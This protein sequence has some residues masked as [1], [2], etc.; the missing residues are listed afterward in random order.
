MAVRRLRRAF[1]STTVALL[2]VGVAAVARAEAP[3][4]S[5]RLAPEEPLVEL[6]RRLFFEPAASRFG[7][8]ACADCHAPD[9]G[10]SDPAIRSADDFGPTKRHSQSLVDVGAGAAHWDGQF[11][12]VAALVEGRT[13]A[14]T[15]RSASEG[16]YDSD[17]E[18]ILAD[19]LSSPEAAAE[20]K[21]PGSI[22][23]AR[24]RVIVRVVRARAIDRLPA[25]SRYRDAFAAAGKKGQEVS[26]AATVAAALGAYCHAIRSA[27]SPFDRWRAGDESALPETAKLGYRLFVGRGGCSACHSVEGARPTFTDGAF[28]DTGIAWHAIAAGK[29]ALPGDVGRFA[30]TKTDSDVRAFKTPT[31]RDV[32]RHPPY[33]HDGSCATL[34]AAVRHY[35]SGPIDDPALDSRNP[36]HQAEDYEVAALVAFL[37]ALTSDVRPGLAPSAWTA[38]AKRT[39]LELVDHAKRPLAGRRVTVYPAGDA[40]P[41]GRGGVQVGTTD[42]QGRVEYEVPASTHARVVVDDGLPIFGGSLLPDTSTE[43]RL[44]VDVDGEIEATVVF[45]AGADVPDRIQARYVGWVG[46]PGEPT[47][48]AGLRVRSSGPTADGTIVASYVGDRPADLTDEMDVLVPLRGVR[49]AT[50]LSSSKPASI[51]LSR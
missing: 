31:L 44:V 34:E 35:L 7:I 11:D 2:G 8:H 51:D 50:R 13:G 15:G 39:R 16:Y 10:F 9:H 5:A 18:R 43:E 36:T 12:T 33:M 4:P 27:E 24:I 28:H 1:V 40:V 29:A 20:R 17:L 26:S 45:P 38:R 37:E 6:G 3:P 49:L 23:M 48:R 30:F 19:A 21:R 41:Q 42:A 22:E 47:P 46:L 25:L 14:S 32:A